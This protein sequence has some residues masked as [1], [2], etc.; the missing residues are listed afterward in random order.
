MISRQ[1]QPWLLSFATFTASTWTG[2]RPSRLPAFLARP[3]PITTRS[4][5]NERS[6]SATAPIT[7]KKE[8]DGSRKRGMSP[9]IF[10]DRIPCMWRT[11]N[12]LN[13]FDVTSGSASGTAIRSNNNTAEG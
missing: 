8:C 1:E 13:G 7:V 4:R 5:I 10:H 2:G 9:D 6:S 11:V 12:G 3:K